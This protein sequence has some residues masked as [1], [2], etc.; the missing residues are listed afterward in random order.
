M[1][2]NLIKHNW[3]GLKECVLSKLHS[4]NVQCLMLDCP[5]VSF[6]WE[7]VKHAFNVSGSPSSAN[8]LWSIW[9]RHS[10]P[11]VSRQLWDT[12]VAIVYWDIWKESVV[13]KIRLLSG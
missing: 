11:R 7:S 5:F 4:E 12:V 2:D 6:I 3:E 9:H 1:R 10:I 13:V 8:D